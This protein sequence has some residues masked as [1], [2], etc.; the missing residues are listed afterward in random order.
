MI[1]YK[2]NNAP[3]VMQGNSVICNFDGKN[4]VKVSGK[5]GKVLAKLGYRVEDDSGSE[6]TFDDAD[7]GDERTGSD[8]PSGDGESGD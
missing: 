7:S 4:A 5:A 2:D 6:S 8:D 3:V 1:A